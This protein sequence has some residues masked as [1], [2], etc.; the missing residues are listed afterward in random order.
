[1]SMKRSIFRFF[2][3]VVTLCLPFIC[4]A[5]GEKGGVRSTNRLH[6]DYQGWERMIPTHAK[7]QYAGGM[8]FL[9]AGVGWDYGR[10]NRWETDL[11]VGFLPKTYSDRFHMTFTLRQNYI[12]WSINLTPRFAIE[13]F[14]CGIYGNIISGERFWLKGPERY[15]GESS[16]YKFSSRLRFH[17]YVGQRFTLFTDRSSTLRA[18]SLYYELSINDLMVVS[19]FNNRTL[20]LSDVVHFSLGVKAQLF[21]N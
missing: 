2:V 1:M 12:P 20:E 4:H 6:A 19:K 11:M 5:G 7:L 8:G 13:P 16:Y 18:L 14:S 15:P 21:G 3:T 17:F 9:S 10:Q